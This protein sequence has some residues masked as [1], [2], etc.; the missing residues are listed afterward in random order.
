[1]RKSSSAALCLGF[2]F[3]LPR[4]LTRRR[5]GPGCPASATMPTCAAAP[6]RA[7]PRGRDQQ[8][9]AA[10]G[11][12]N[13]LDPGGF[14]TVTIGKS[15]TIDGEG[16][17]AGVL[18][19]H[20]SGIS[21]IIINGAGIKVTLR[22]L[23]IES[24][25]VGG[26]STPGGIGINV[27]NASEVPHR[28]LLDRP[29][30]QPRHQLRPERRRRGRFHQ[31]RHRRQQWRQRRQRGEQ[32]ARVGQP[33]QLLYQR[34]RGSCAATDRDGPEQ[35]P[36][37]AASGSERTRPRRPQ[38]R[39]QRDDAQRQRDLVAGGATVRV[40]NSLIVSNVTNGLNMTAAA[41]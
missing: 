40:N 25:T 19:I 37:A 32:L 30:H 10:G 38:P 36:W 14:G 35:R 7:R 24:P 11:F 5:R 29:V 3:G 26:P 21:G 23:S 8:D 12:I 33:A 41:R 39:K 18:A 1:M 22:N 31:R 34:R 20:E 27:L 17:H 16:T 9:L 4:W 2:A 28:E 6:R 13:V 15:L